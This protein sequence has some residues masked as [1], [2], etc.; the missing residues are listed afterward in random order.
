MPDQQTERVLE[1]VVFKLKQGATREQLLSTV[2]AVS[3]WAR[4]RPGFLSRDLAYSAAEDRWI[5]VIW[6]RTLAEAEAAAEAALSSA[7]CAPMFG[8]I[9]MDSPQMLHGVP[10]IAPVSR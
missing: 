10:A 2:D 5:E 3:A 8:L 7:D 6:W 1:L 4:T 9:D